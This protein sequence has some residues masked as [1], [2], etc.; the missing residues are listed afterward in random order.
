MTKMFVLFDME[1]CDT[2]LEMEIFN[3]FLYN[4]TDLDYDE[5]NAI[6][7]NLFSYGNV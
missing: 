6:D 1:V 4:M 7:F 3:K 5:L 2:R